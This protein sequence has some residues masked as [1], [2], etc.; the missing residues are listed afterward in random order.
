[1][2]LNTK[3]YITHLSLVLGVWNFDSSLLSA[4]PRQQRSPFLIMPKKFHSLQVSWLF[5]VLYLEKLYVNGWGSMASDSVQDQVWFWYSGVQLCI[6]IGFASN[7]ATSRALLLQFDH[8]QRH[9]RSVVM[10]FTHDSPFAAVWLIREVHSIVLRVVVVP[11]TLN[12]QKNTSGKESR[13]TSKC[14]KIFWF[15]IPTSPNFWGGPVLCPMLMFSPS[16]LHSYV[17]FFLEQI[18]Y[19]SLC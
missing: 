18:F 7:S 2:K 11:S 8:D 14:V 12:W 1:M 9:L 13:Q 10:I 4:G 15:E 5:T 16:T 17:P 19:A 3:R 6:L